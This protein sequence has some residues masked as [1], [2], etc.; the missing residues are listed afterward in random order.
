MGRQ[1]TSRA[2]DETRQTRDHLAFFKTVAFLIKRLYQKAAK[3]A[4]RVS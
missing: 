3:A 4:S 1:K 2:G